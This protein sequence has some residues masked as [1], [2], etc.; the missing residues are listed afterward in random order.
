MLLRRCLSAVVI[1]L[2]L[3][4]GVFPHGGGIDAYGGHNDRRAGGYHFHHGTLK[5]QS[6]ATKAEGIAALRNAQGNSGGS[7]AIS[8]YSGSSKQAATTDLTVYITKTGKK[9]HKAS[10]RHLRSSIPINL[11][12]AE[13]RGYTACSVCGGK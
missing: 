4:T 1:A 13:S 10:C 5:G 9:Y 2:L 11:S 8:R 3:P 12:D 7:T 6:F